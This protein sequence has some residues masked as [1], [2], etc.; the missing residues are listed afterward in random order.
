MRLLFVSALL[1]SCACKSPPPHEPA[2]WAVED[3]DSHAICAGRRTGERTAD[4]LVAITIPRD[5]RT[6]LRPEGT[7]LDEGAF[8]IAFDPDARL[9]VVALDPAGRVSV[10]AVA[11]ADPRHVQKAHDRRATGAEVYLVREER[12]GDVL[13][14][15][16][17][18]LDGWPLEPFPLVA[19]EW[20]VTTQEVRGWRPDPWRGAKGVG[21]VVGVTALLAGVGWIVAEEIDRLEEEDD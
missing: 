16:I 17:C 1:L 19:F 7:S 5:W 20:N 15:E 8:S 2:W 3:G 18:G 13:S 9:D 4:A 11:E 21:V 10:F 12:E 6:R 14:V